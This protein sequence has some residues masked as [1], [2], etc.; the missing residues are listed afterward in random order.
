MVPMTQAA[1]PR[2]P[3]S[4]ALRPSF[5]PPTSKPGIVGQHVEHCHGLHRLR[6][7]HHHRHHL[8]VSLDRI[9]SPLIEI[10]NAIHLHC[11]TITPCPLPSLFTTFRHCTQI[12]R[13]SPVRPELI[14]TRLPIR[15]DSPFSQHHDDSGLLCFATTSPQ[16]C[17][18]TRLPTLSSCLTLRQPHT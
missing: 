7:H 3:S 12:P 10:I 15:S 13:S 4:S 2:P 17:V 16:A 1:G 11:I 14:P 6:L 5:G 8:I 18:A 9:S